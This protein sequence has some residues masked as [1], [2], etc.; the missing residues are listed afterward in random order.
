M[1]E[2]REIFPRMAI[3]E[4]NGHSWNVGQPRYPKLARKPVSFLQ[5][6]K[7][8]FPPK[9]NRTYLK[10][11]SRIGFPIAFPFVVVGKKEKKEG[12][13]DRNDGRPLCFCGSKA[14]ETET[15]RLWPAFAEWHV[16]RL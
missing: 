14:S 13:D 11:S 3:P 10:K 5:H 4:V 15:R 2:C 7:T 9:K 6:I 12:K 8:E 16:Q 1:G